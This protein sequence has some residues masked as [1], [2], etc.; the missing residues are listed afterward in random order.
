MDYLANEKPRLAFG[1]A[2]SAV[3]KKYAIFTGRARRSEYWWF[4]LA[5]TLVTTAFQLA[6]W[7]LVLKA[8]EC[9]YPLAFITIPAYMTLTVLAGLFYIFMALP[10]FAVAVRRMHDIGKSGW[11][12]LFGLIPIIGWVLLLVWL[13]QDS[14]VTINKYGNSPKYGYASN[15]SNKGQ[16]A[17]SSPWII[18]IFMF[19][20]VILLI[21][22]LG[23]IKPS[24]YEEIRLLPAEEVDA[25]TVE[26]WFVPAETEEED[27]I[28]WDIVNNAYIQVLDEHSQA[29]AESEFFQ[30]EYFLFDITG[31]GTPELW[32]KSGTCEADYTLYIYTY[33]NGIKQIYEGGAGHSG[34]YAGENYVIQMCAHMGYSTW[35]KITY[36][37]TIKVAEVWNEGTNRTDDDYKMPSESYI[38]MTPYR[39]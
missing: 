39:Q 10:Y 28:D 35:Y 11:N 37:G 27:V 15:E 1:E 8:F 3:L 14:D 4:V 12:I 17:P 7:I 30:C 18:G 31:N 20:A 24:N 21:A 22:I 19:A 23:E 29:N 2:L 25:T 9:G 6:Q 32:I 36:N 26:E 5:Y 33:D 16:A 34:F 13:C 38:E